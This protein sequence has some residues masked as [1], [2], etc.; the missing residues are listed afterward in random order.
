MPAK[1]LRYNRNGWPFTNNTLPI[2]NLLTSA[3]MNRNFIWEQKMKTMKK[4]ICCAM[5][6]AV[7]CLFAGC[8]TVHGAGEDVEKGGQKIQ[9]ESEEH[10]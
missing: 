8:H 10:M 4:V 7:M 2:G 1:D 6:L 3:A 9:Q 5:L